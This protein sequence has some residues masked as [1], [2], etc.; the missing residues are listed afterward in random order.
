[1]IRIKNVVYVWPATNAATGQVLA[2]TSAG[3]L[4][5][6]NNGQ[7]VTAGT[8]IVLT[9][10]GQVVT[11]NSSSSGSGG[12]VT[13]NDGSLVNYWQTNSADGSITNINGGNGR[14][15]VSGTNAT[16]LS[17]SLT[18][19]KPLFV[20]RTNGQQSILVRS[21]GSLFL[22]KDAPA[23]G[24]IPFFDPM[25]LEQVS[26]VDSNGPTTIYWEMDSK[27]MNG[28][29]ESVQAWKTIADKDAP[30]ST[31]ESTAQATNGDSR[32]IF[33]VMSP[34]ASQITYQSNSID[35]FTVND[36]GDL[37][38]IRTIGYHW[39]ST[40][41]TAGKVLATDGG[42]PQQLYWTNQ[43]SS[44]GGG[45][46]GVGPG[47]LNHLSMFNSTTTNVIDSNLIQEATNQWAYKQSS[48]TWTNSVTNVWYERWT[49]GSSNRGIQL[50][51]N[52]NLAELKQFANGTIGADV[53]GGM[54]FNDAWLINGLGTVAA[55]GHNG[56]WL[57]LADSDGT[58]G[59]TV[60]NGTHKVKYIYLST[61]SAGGVFF[62]DGGHIQSAGIDTTWGGTAWVIH[63]TPDNRDLLYVDTGGVNGNTVRIGLGQI[64]ASSGASPGTITASDTWLMAGRLAGS[65]QL[66]T[67]NSGTGTAAEGRLTGSEALGTD[68]TG[69]TL[70][71]G[72]G[73]GNGTGRGGDLDIETAQKASGSSSS[74]NP[75]QKR[76]KISSEPVT[77]TTNSA[78]TV[79][80]FTVPTSLTM[81]G[82]KF[83]ATTEIKDAT[84]VAALTEEFR[85]VAIN[86]AATVTA[87]NS[88]PSATSYLATGSVGVSTTWTVTVSSTTVSIK[89][90]AVTTGIN[91][92]TARVY[93]RLELDSDGVSV[94]NFQ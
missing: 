40:N 21:D 84:D 22:G 76:L 26:N 30:Q 51:E 39:P 19:G 2:S 82:A 50:I 20:G 18:T 80:T 45:G 73:N 5:Y 63:D 29:Y 6:T 77:L 85:I 72:G 37:T 78:T 12:G 3:L 23:N 8:N 42:S 32:R 69:G 35:T 90:N 54:R 88:A 94:V 36:S 28:S 91:A 31:W 49:S 86:K 61:G 58:T 17:D 89:C 60:G 25:F 14:V 27:G 10:N 65:W 38:H 57:P 71:L 79:C 34:G 93:G 11:I 16:I 4:Y 62:P 68:H 56:D 92:T 59:L 1:M 13:N 41:G 81:V 83:S 46:G 33:Y 44:G 43:N 52:G 64:G 53:F 7:V 15:Y 66:Q 67:N 70:I 74:S 24:D 48:S 87:T 9:T 75:Y 47:T 55:G